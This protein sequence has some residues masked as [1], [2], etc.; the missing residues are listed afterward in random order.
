MVNYTKARKA[1]ESLYEGSCTVYIQD[2]RTNPE[3]KETEFTEITTITDEPCRL[4]FATLV[5]TNI[6]DH[7]PKLGQAVKVFMSP[8]VSVPPGSKL[9]VTQNGITESYSLSGEPARY[10]T[11]QEIPV[12]LFKGWA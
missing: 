3:T 5:S 1:I 9:V 7:A 8:G 2:K 10:A 4:S 11:H 6:V 12:E